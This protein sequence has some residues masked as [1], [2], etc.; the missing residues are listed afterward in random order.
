MR[1]CRGFH[2][3]PISDGERIW[4]VCEAMTRDAVVRLDDTELGPIGPG[5]R[6][7]ARDVTDQLDDRH[8]L[9]FQ[10]SEPCDELPWREVRLEIRLHSTPE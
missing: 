1:L 3:P 4:I 9:T 10:L 7:W 2:R 6:L 5:E 8:E